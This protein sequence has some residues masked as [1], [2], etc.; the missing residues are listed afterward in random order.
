MCRVASLRVHIA[1][2]S[3]R[4]S[5]VAAAAAVA[6]SRGVRLAFCLFGFLSASSVSYFVSRFPDET[7]RFSMLGVGFCGCS[8]TRHLGIVLS[9]WGQLLGSSVPC[10]PVLLAVVYR[11]HL[12]WAASESAQGEAAASAM[13]GR[14]RGPAF[15]GRGGRGMRRR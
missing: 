14:G 1:V 9:A 11:E 13:G 4:V 5:H 10:Y 15:G 12:C 6:S 8:C 7:L 2:M 3:L